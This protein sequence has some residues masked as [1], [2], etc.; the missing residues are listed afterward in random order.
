MINALILSLTL[1]ANAGCQLSDDITLVDQGQARHKIV[2][3]TTATTAETRAAEILQKYVLLISGDKPQMIRE[4]NYKEGEPAIFIGLTDHS[5]K[6]GTEKIKG[7][8]FI[9]SSDD[10]NLYVRAGSGKGQ[11]MEFTL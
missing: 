4:N 2:I 9:I 10:K 11:F 8:G 5:E 3:S 7:E 6:W 1:V